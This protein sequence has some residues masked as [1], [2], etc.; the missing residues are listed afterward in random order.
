MLGLSLGTYAG[1]V[2]LSLLCH[3]GACWVGTDLC[4]GKE[5]GMGWGKS[6]WPTHHFPGPVC[7]NLLV[8]FWCSDLE[9]VVPV[10]AGLS[11]NVIAV[12]A[13]VRAS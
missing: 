5:G 3:R 6:L 11:G 13:A 10:R 9:N 1:A 7:P 4:Q 8:S 2:T 12:G